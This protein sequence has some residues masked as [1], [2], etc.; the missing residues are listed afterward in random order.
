VVLG[1]LVISL[2]ATLIGRLWYLQVLA[3]PQFVA[4]AKDNQVRDIVTEAPRGEIVDDMGRPLVDNKTALVISVD[5]IALQRQPDGGV[6]VLHRLSKLVGTPYSLLH[7]EIRL[8]GA[9]PNN[10]FVSKPCWAGSPYE[11][12]PVS[13]LKPGI[14][15]TRRALQ[16]EEMQEKFPGVT[17]QLAAVRHY[18][19]PAGALASSILGYITPI[20]PQQL[21]ALPKNKQDVMRNTMVGATGLEQSYEKYLH[22]KPGLKQ[23]TVDHVGAV[24]GTVKNTQPRQGDDVVTY[25]DAKAQANLEHQLQVAINTARGSGY[26]ADYAAGVVLNARNGGIVAMS[27]IPT[28]NPRKPPPS[29]KSQHKFQ[30]FANSKG[31]PFVDKAYGS[32]NP[33]GSTFKPISSTGLVADGTMST[34]GAYDCPTYFQG[35]HNFDTGGGRGYISLHEAIVVSC[36]TYFFKL[37]FQDWVRDNNLIKAG[38]K[39]REG[40]QH[41]ARAYGYGED[42]R[43]DLPNAAYG[44]IADRYNTKLFWKANAHKGLNYCKGAR[45]RPKGSYVQQLDAEF[46]Q[47][48][49]T[50]KAGDQEN[51]DVGQG[52]VLISPL[53]EAV[54]YAAL[55]NGGK[56][57]EPRVVKAIVS[58]TG[59]VIKRV[60]APIRDHLPVSQATLAY[61]RSAMYGV[62]SE[63]S[64]TAKAAFSGYPQSK[65]QIGGKTGTAE[66]SGTSQNGS[67]FGSFGGPTGQKPQYVT[68]IEVDKSNQG[69]ISAAPF[70]R[71]MWDALYGFGGAKPI[72]KN[73]IPPTALPKVG[74]AAAQAKFARQQARKQHRQQKLQQQAAKAS[75]SAAA[76]TTASPTTSS[77]P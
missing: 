29:Y 32:T 76:T 43:V 27:S 15:S 21:K 65:V 30:K 25:L 36:D 49:Y 4:Q 11:P 9:G 75:A 60:H 41:I 48:G 34:S 67:W 40:V 56:V 22:G 20:S 63:S 6:K 35:R 39:P 3:A 33:P 13:Q 44:H 10:T 68:V 73:G 62:T 51:E 70:V 66:L 58:P 2:V 45:T 8:C 16:I 47:T 31:F 50:F 28:Y 69:A 37:G 74:A 53:Q 26:T 24:T 38:Q 14:G 72:F 23:V 71:N 5:R 1:V 77:S 54:A 19:K 42:P 12:I 17:A 59:K 64:G 46:C 61:L 18:P 55:A 7:R 52:S 57:F